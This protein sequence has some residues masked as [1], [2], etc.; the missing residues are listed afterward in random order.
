MSTVPRSPTDI[1]RAETRP[2]VLVAA[3]PDLD[4]VVR[5]FEAAAES[6]GIDRPTGAE[7]MRLCA[8]VAALTTELFPEGFHIRVKNDPEIPNDLYFV[9]A[10]R[11]TG[12]TDRIVTQ[13]DQWHRRI[14]Q[15]EGSR[16]GLFRL[17]INAH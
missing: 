10:A 2:A 6:L 8:E 9:F 15:S 13:N 3:R 16:H 12:D 5:R 7:L 4:E 1:A 14:R 17:A 11:A